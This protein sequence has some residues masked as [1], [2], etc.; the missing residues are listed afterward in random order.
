MADP[1]DHFPA[2]TR[3]RSLTRPL[4]VRNELATDA[5]LA[6]P[7][8]TPAAASMIPSSSMSTKAPPSM[9]L[10]PHQGPLSFCRALSSS[11][12]T[13]PGTPAFPAMW[14]RVD[15]R[16]W[17]TAIA[18]IR[19]SSSSIDAAYARR[20]SEA[21]MRLAPPPGRIPSR[22]AERVA[23]RASSTRSIRSLSSTS[24]SAPTSTTAMPLVRR[25]SRRVYSRMHSSSE[26][27]SSAAFPE[28]IFCFSHSRS[29]RVCSARS[30]TLS[31]FERSP[32]RV[33]ICLETSA[34]GTCPRTSGWKCFLS[35]V[36]F[37]VS[38]TVAFDRAAMSLRFSSL[39]A[40]IPGARIA[41]MSIPPFTLARVIPWITLSE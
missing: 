15:C 28:R 19:F 3:I 40:V 4:I 23:R 30:S 14:Y 32:Y 27:S 12:T 18:P 21:A 11:T 24:V 6:T 39:N 10:Y 35:V 31:R 36:P 38:S 2:I 26:P 13:S 20:R 22:S 5:A 8:L 33:V 17:A 34:S 25:P 7:A 41:Q 29:L 37:I 16:A 1:P 9:T